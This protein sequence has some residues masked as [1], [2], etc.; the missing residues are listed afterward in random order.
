MATTT[1]YN[2]NVNLFRFLQLLSKI[3]TQ[4]TKPLYKQ[5]SGEQ[6]KSKQNQIV[7]TEESEEAF[8][9]LK[10]ICSQT[11]ILA[12]SNY[13][14]PFKVHTDAPEWGLGA[15]LYQEQ[16]D[17]TSRVIV[18]TSQSLSNSEKCYHSSKLE[19]LA[20]KWAITDQFPKYLYG[21]QF[22]VYTNNNPL[23]YILTMAKLDATA[24]WWVA[25]LANY[26]FSIHYKSGKQNI[27]A[28]ALSQIDLSQ[29]DVAAALEQGCTVEC[30][31]PLILPPEIMVKTS[32]VGELGL[33]ISTEDW[34]KEQ[35][36]DQSIGW[37]MKLL[38]ENKLSGYKSN[39]SDSEQF[40]I[41]LKYRRDMVLKNGLLY[42]KTKLK[43][44]TVL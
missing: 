15:V 8:T 16:E 3:H 43:T 36:A 13:Q 39:N 40:R 32:I 11:P 24:Q 5:I 21:G 9:K 1:N 37:I 2:V 17:H 30:S 29:I 41:Y 20:L 4:I 42:W 12:Y 22:E 33:K 7:W 34:K 27:E 26:N 23:T 35:Q 38:Q 31:L 6:A 10:N 25:S 18:F 44:M 14:K 28:N 19:F